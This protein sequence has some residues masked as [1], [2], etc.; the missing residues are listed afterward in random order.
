MSD[1]GAK[2]AQLDRVAITGHG[3]P[4]DGKLLVAQTI[5]KPGKKAPVFECFETV[6]EDDQRPGVTRYIENATDRQRFVGVDRESHHTLKRKRITSPSCTT[7]SF[8]SLRI[9][10]AA[11]AACSLPQLT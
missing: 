1:N 4:A 2:I 5:G 10:P 3:E 9:F 7:Y 8:P 6:N 11:R